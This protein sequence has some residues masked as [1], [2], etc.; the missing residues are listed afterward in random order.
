[1]CVDVFV[2]LHNNRKRTHL[3]KDQ[4]FFLL[5]LSS[6][7]KKTYL[8]LNLENN[9]IIISCYVILMENFP[10]NKSNPLES[11][12]HFNQSYFRWS[13]WWTPHQTAKNHPHFL[14]LPHSQYNNDINRTKNTTVFPTHQIIRSSEHQTGH[15]IKLNDFVCCKVFTTPSCK[16][17]NQSAIF[18]FIGSR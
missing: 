9:I 1:M 17:Q 14:I 6:W 11:Q 12:T 15:T 4:V 3:I 10:Y 7:K 2:I 13:S 5:R 16:K 8:V 18:K